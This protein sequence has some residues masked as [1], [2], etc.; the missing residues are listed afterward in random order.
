VP[1]AA[2]IHGRRDEARPTDDTE[3]EQAGVEREDREPERCGRREV[4][5]DDG[6]AVVRPGRPLP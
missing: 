2:V 5:E 1:D 4:E 3:R 6:F